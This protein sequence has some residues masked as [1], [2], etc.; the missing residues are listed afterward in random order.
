MAYGEKYKL[1]FDTIISK[2]KNNNTS[3]TSAIFKAS[4]YQDGFT[5]SVTDVIGNSDPVKIETSRNSEIGYKP[6]IGT[7]ATF[8]MIIDQSFDLGQFMTCTGTDYYLLVQAGTRTDTYSGGVYVSSTYTWGDI[9]YKGFYLPITEVSI[10][11]VGPYEFKMVFS[12]G[13]HFMKNSPYYLGLTGQFLGFGANDRVS[14][15][16]LITKSL[17]KSNLGFNFSVSFFFENEDIAHTGS[18]RQL[19]EIYVYKNGLVKDAGT[20][21]NYYEILEFILIRFGLVCYQAKGKWFIMDYKEMTNGTTAPRVVNYDV[22]GNYLSSGTT[23]FN[24]ITVNGTDFRQLGQSQINRL[25]LPKNYIQFN[26]NLKKFVRNAIKN[27]EFQAWIDST[28]I[29]SWINPG[30]LVDYERYT[31]GTGR[32]ALQINGATSSTAY[33]VS[34]QTTVKAGDNLAIDWSQNTLLAG[35]DTEIDIILA[36]D[37]GL[38]YHLQIDLS[39]DTVFESAPNKFNESTAAL[40]GIDKVV[41]IPTPGKVYV[42]IFQPTNPADITYFEFMKI[43]VYGGADSGDDPAGKNNVISIVEKGNSNTTFTS[44]GMEY[45]NTFY[46]YDYLV[47]PHDYIN[48]EQDLIDNTTAFIGYMS[49]QYYNVLNDNWYYDN[50]VSPNYLYIWVL[51]NMAKNVMQN[52]VVIDGDFL[53]T[54]PPFNNWF[55]YNMIGIGTKKYICM[56]YSWSLKQATMNANLYSIDLITTNPTI[57]PIKYLN[58]NS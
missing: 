48:N 44:V 14:L 5:G 49:D 25:G 23:T 56:D 38:T 37:S 52:F 36:A 29:Y 32:Y 21:Y 8:T 4:I 11:D 2:T 40:S 45:E 35:Y 20:Y 54:T 33:L 58:Y 6:I 7:K 30:S 12:D 31:L 16:E 55:S 22:N 41:R 17:E 28:T 34:N 47:L 57:S 43:Q 15:H 39:G 27:D 19:E 24:T 53:T 50:S 51:N 3:S 46:N 26:T 18:K 1:I 13:T 42:R 9:V 10:P